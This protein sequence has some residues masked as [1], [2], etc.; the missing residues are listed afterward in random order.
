[1]EG[2]AYMR[3]FLRADATRRTAQDRFH[4]G[5]PGEEHPSVEFAHLGAGHGRRSFRHENRRDTGDHC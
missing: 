3:D 2:L 4:S 5:G 1:M